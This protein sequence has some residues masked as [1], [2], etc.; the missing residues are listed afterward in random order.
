[1]REAAEAE[2]LVADFEHLALGGVVARDRIAY[3]R[4]AAEGRGVREAPEPDAKAVAEMEEWY[5]AVFGEAT[6]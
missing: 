2:A 6:G 4:A 5:R 3:R 1:M